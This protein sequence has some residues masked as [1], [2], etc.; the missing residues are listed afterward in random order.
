M[1]VCPEYFALDISP[2]GFIRSVTN[3]TGRGGEATYDLQERERGREE[4][5]KGLRKGGGMCM[6]ILDGRESV[7]QR[8]ERRF[9][10]ICVEN[11]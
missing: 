9:N 2:N 6:G 3:K 4:E 10:I 1:R 11:V 7:A 8:K 5:E